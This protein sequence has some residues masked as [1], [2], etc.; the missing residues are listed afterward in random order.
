M[1]FQRR[2]LLSDIYE[3]IDRS[4]DA[5]KNHQEEIN[6]LRFFIEKA[7]E[8]FKNETPELYNK[9]E[10]IMNKFSE[11]LDQEQLIQQCE[12]RVVEDFNDIAARFDVIF[13]TSEETVEKTSAVKRATTTITKLREDLNADL[14]KGGA[15]QAK[16]QNEI[17]NTIEIKKKA[18]GEAEI[19][20]KEFIAVKEKYN[21]FKVRRLQHAY[22]SFG[23]ILLQTSSKLSEL[24]EQLYSECMISGDIINSLLENQID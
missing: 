20:I 13:R 17:T 23:E 12:N 9:F 11:I 16:I 4:N 21:S 1:A 22:H 14:A 3:I 6:N 15:K 24:Y 5:A 18:I 8:L 19:K 2:K 10:N 7:K